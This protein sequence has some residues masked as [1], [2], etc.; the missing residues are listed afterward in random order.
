MGVLN[1]TPDSFSDGGRYLEP[2]NAVEQ[3][4]RMAEQGAKIIDIGGESTRPGSDP[5]SP[6]EQIRRIVPVIQRLKDLPAVISVDTTL[7]EVAEAA[8]DAGAA[9]IND[10][11]AGRDDPE[12]F[13]LVSRRRCPMIL[14]HMQGHPKTM[15]Q[16]PH[17]TDVVGEI[18]GFLEQQLVTAG[19][20]G[21][22]AENLLVDP[23]IGFG[24]TTIHN[25]EIL[26]ELRM[27][28]TLGRPLV[29]GTS[30]KRFIGEILGQ[31]DP[32]LRL[33]GTAATV[34]WSLANGASVVRVH[35]VEPIA[36]I[37]RMIHAIADGLPENLTI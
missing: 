9:I 25:L 28:T 30:R 27:L 22:S 36:Q 5:V 6:D 4:F 26:R 12:M 37:V 14:M 8:L 21:I 34:A 33:W 15:Q 13:S 32:Q 3:A 31:S 16:S 7:T 29:V 1:I 20:H 35:D 17:Y 23:G 24:K 11:S 18:M 10:I 19:I 2:E